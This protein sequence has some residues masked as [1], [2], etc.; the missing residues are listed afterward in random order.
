MAFLNGFDFDIFLSYGWSGNQQPDRG[1]RAWTA[2]FVQ[3]LERELGDRLSAPIRIFFDQRSSRNGSLDD[4]LAQALE[5]SGLFLFLVA[6]GSCRPD[7]WCRRELRHFLDRGAPISFPGLNIIQRIFK[8]IL[9]P[10]ERDRQPERLHPIVGYEFFEWTSPAA[11][12]ENYVPLPLEHIS[13]R[14]T[15]AYAEFAKLAADLARALGRAREQQD[16]ARLASG[17]KIFMGAVPRELRERSDRLRSDLESRGHRVFAASPLDG[18]ANDQDYLQKGLALADVSIHLLA[19]EDAAA[20]R[21][22]RSACAF[23]RAEFQTYVWSDPD[24]SKSA[25]LSDVRNLQNSGKVKLI[26]SRGFEYFASN[27]EEWL[28]RPAPLS[29][30]PATEPVL[31]PSQ[32]ASVFGPKAT[33]LIQFKPEDLENAA[34][35]AGELQGKGL[36][37]QFP[38]FGG[39]SSDRNKRNYRYFQES[40]GI[41]VYFG[42]SSDLWTLDTCEFISRQ[43]GPALQGKTAAVCVGPPP[44]RPPNKK[45]FGT[46]YKIDGFEIVNWSP[47]SDHGPL[48]RWTDKVAL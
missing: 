18:E 7:G 9:R 13:R 3:L 38:V 36:F 44:D 19:G 27:V 43:L 37:V 39:R 32:A 10:V 14:E 11:E 25:F 8:L 41:I 35:L 30:I 24:A 33:V 21:Q 5:S 2:G 12:P 17:V 34:K 4:N 47:D 23:D 1:D 31:V 42:T 16:K 15:K 28:K 29:A 45:F 46:N 40:T 6:P 20:E 48:H 26:E 22:V